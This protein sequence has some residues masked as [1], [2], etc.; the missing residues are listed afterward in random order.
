[1]AGAARPDFSAPSVLHYHHAPSC[2]LE[3]VV[4]PGRAAGI[5]H[6]AAAA[7]EC[8][9]QRHAC[10][11]DSLTDAWPAQEHRAAAIVRGDHAAPARAAAAQRWRPHPVHG[12]SG[13]SKEQ[14]NS[15][16]AVLQSRHTSQG[17]VL[18]DVQCIARVL[19]EPCAGAGVSDKLAA[20]APCH[21][22]RRDC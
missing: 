3:P 4:T 1:M 17:C 12:A 10:M 11:G 18:Q 9:H 16:E 8:A 15:R 20:T 6:P 5:K 13:S 14:R 21:S 2:P 19:V 22:A 7:S